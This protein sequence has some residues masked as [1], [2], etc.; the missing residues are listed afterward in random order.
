MTDA[1]STLRGSYERALAAKTVPGYWEMSYATALFLK[2]GGQDF[3]GLPVNYNAAVPFGE[4]G[5][6][7]ADDSDVVWNAI[8]S[9]GTSSD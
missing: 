7:P 6:Y 1:P 4:W 8:Q 2:I 5:L 9:G 3:C